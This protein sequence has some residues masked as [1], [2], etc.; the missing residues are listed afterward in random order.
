MNCLISFCTFSLVYSIRELFLEYLVL[1]V[2]FAFVHLGVKAFS[3]SGR[4][5][6]TSTCKLVSGY[7]FGDEGR[8]TFLLTLT[9]CSCISRPGRKRCK[10]IHAYNFESPIS[11]T[12]L[13]WGRMEWEKH[14]DYT[15]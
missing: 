2:H 14:G 1:F 5:K 4:S 8:V 15:R 12:S 7:G 10:S 9:L 11:S 3:S 6:T 13:D